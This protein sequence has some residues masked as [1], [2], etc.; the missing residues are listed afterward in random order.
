MNKVEDLNK[1]CVEMEDDDSLPLRS[2]A[3]LVFGE[4][5]ID[6][7]VLFVGEAP[8]SNEDKLGRP[9]VG[10]SGKLLDKFIERIGWKRKEVYITNIVKRRPPL[11]R[12]PLPEEIEAY[13]PYLIRQIEIISPKV[14]VPLG[15]FAMNH[16]LPTAKISLDQGKIFWWKDNI[17]IM[18]IYHPAAALRSTTVLK[19]TKKTFAKLKT[20][21]QKYP[22]LVQKRDRVV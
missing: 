12:D 10:R 7:D 15:R 22:N 6:S 9:F 2:D 4:G 18:P 17:I 8:G 19:K 20:I 1:L 11:N 3:N 16:F 5:D 21:V 13:T 14:I